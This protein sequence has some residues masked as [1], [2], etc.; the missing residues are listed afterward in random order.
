MQNNGLSFVVLEL[1]PCRLRILQGEI[2]TSI[3]CIRWHMEYCSNILR[4]FIKPSLSFIHGS[5]VV[6][7]EMLLILRCHHWSYFMRYFLTS[8]R[9]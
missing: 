9:Q 6:F 4:E 7:L 5:V 1:S 3:S 8:V 2:P